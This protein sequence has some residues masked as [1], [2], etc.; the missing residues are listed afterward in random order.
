MILYPN[1]RTVIYRKEA[2]IY[3]PEG[4]VRIPAKA[5]VIGEDELYY[6][7]RIWIEPCWKWVDGKEIEYT[8]EASTGIH[9]SRVIGFVN[10]QLSLFN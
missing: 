2:D 5:T 10:E 4:W 1:P 9:K 3:G 6:V 8:R 7:T